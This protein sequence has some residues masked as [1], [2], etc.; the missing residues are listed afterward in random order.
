MAS[1]R[2][3]GGS[4]EGSRSVE[5]DLA[6]APRQSS[7]EGGALL[8]V[9]WWWCCLGEAADDL[10]I[11]ALVLSFAASATARRPPTAASRRGCK[12]SERCRELRKG[13][14]IHLQIFWKRKDVCST[15]SASGDGLVLSLAAASPAQRLDSPLS[16]AQQSSC[17]ASETCRELLRGL[18]RH[19]QVF[20][21]GLRTC[22]VPTLVPEQLGGEFRRKRWPRTSNCA[23]DS[24]PATPLQSS[25][26]ASEAC[27]ELLRG[28]IKYLRTFQ[29]V[30]GHLQ[31]RPCLRALRAQSGDLRRHRAPRRFSSHPGFPAASREEGGVM[32]T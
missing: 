15:A 5:P 6:Q 19:L 31:H 12:T 29:A 13:L 1:Q 26:K 16:T 2:A 30:E 9:G 8:T 32:R 10:A 3:Q 27:S 14:H 18:I 7:R 22:A 21:S 28:P 23:T 17:K 20:L 4:K 25:C 24:P 11:A